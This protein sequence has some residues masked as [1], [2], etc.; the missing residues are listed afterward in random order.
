MIRVQGVTKKFGDFTA[1]DN[2]DMVIHEH[3][4]LGMIGPN[5]A[6]KTTFSNLLTGYYAPDSGTV[7]CQGKNITGYSPEKIV[8]LGIVR[9]FQL[10]RVFDNLKVHENLGLSYYRMKKGKSFP[11][12]I[13]RSKLTDPSIR[14]K[15]DEIVQ[16]FELDRLADE[17]T[18]NLSLGNKKKLEIAMA[19]IADPKLLTLD[20]PFAGL[21]SHEIDEIIKIIKPHGKTRTIFLI[22]HKISKLLDLADRLV[23]MHEGRVVAAGN[24]EETLNDP[25]V[26]RVY[27]KIH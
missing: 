8:S 19:F 12:G 25:E 5:G 1:V 4:I 27:W 26:R 3:E 10:V 11:L 22:E 18:G 24:P 14:E 13:L 15:V 2:V 9:T 20:E 21:S 6:G 16:V 23:V 7:F 17:E